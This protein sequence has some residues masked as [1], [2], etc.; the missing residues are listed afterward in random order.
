MNTVRTQ[1]L[2]APL[3]QACCPP[4]LRP[5]PRGRPTPAAKRARAEGAGLATTAPAGVGWPGRPRL[6]LRG[7]TPAAALVAKARPACRPAR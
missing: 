3:P 5:G 4:R 7:D 2:A 1:R 6:R